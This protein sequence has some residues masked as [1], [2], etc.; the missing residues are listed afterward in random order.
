MILFAVYLI[1]RVPFLFDV[2][3]FQCFC[4]KVGKVNWEMKQGYYEFSCIM[5]HSEHLSSDRIVLLLVWSG[6]CDDRFAGIGQ[7]ILCDPACLDLYFYPSI[8]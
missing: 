5:A 4:L 7:N 3:Y 2:L 1:A 6:G 8:F